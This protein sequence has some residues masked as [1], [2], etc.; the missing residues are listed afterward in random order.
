[1]VYRK[2]LLTVAMLITLQILK[3]NIEA[4]TGR[5][6]EPDE[7]DYLVQIRSPADLLNYSDDGTGRLRAL[8]YDAAL[9]LGLCEWDAESAAG[10]H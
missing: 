7:I 3:N 9:A 4:D 6:L 10:D 5:P 1:M 2:G 8:A